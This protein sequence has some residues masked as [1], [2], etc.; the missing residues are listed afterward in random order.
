MKWAIFIKK[1]AHFNL[2]KK[3]SQAFSDC[4]SHAKHFAFG[5]QPVTY[6]TKEYP[7]NWEIGKEAYY[8]VNNDCN[9]ELYKKYKELADQLPNV[10]FGGRLAEYVYYD[11]DKV[12][13]SA[14]RLV[15]KIL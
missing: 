5:K 2:S 15:N 12:V 6:V 9:H 11:M 4:A 10:I 3:S 13:A 8:P 1:I 7:E 14:L